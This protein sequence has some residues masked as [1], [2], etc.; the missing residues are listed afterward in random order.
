M[1]L[2]PEYWVVALGRSA[3]PWGGAAHVAPP[4]FLCAPNGTGSRLL[5]GWAGELKAV[6]SRAL[7][8]LWWLCPVRV[9]VVPS[10]G[11]CRWALAPVASLRWPRQLLPTGCGD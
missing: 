6:P 9:L 8:W 2:F 7:P 10:D 5:R 11:G 4:E 3:S 1:W